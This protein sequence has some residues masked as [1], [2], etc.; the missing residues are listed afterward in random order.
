LIR[1]DQLHAARIGNQYRIAPRDLQQFL[2]V[3]NLPIEVKA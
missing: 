1:L 2:D 3:H